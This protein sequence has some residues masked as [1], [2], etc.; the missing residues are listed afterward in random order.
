MHQGKHTES[1]L[2]SLY[3][4]VVKIF[5]PEKAFVSNTTWQSW[6]DCPSKQGLVQKVLRDALSHGLAFCICPLLPPAFPSPILQHSCSLTFRIWTYFTEH[7]SNNMSQEDYKKE[8]LNLQQMF[9]SLDH[10]RKVVLKFSFRSQHLF[11]LS[12]CS[13]SLNWHKLAVEEFF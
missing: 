3:S 5:V 12:P 8:Q 13:F 11:I 1:T 9:L 2:V 7:E 4:S 10:K 6:L